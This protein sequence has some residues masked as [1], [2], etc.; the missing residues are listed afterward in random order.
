MPTYAQLDMMQSAFEMLTASENVDAA[1]EAFSMDLTAEQPACFD[2]TKNYVQCFSVPDDIDDTE[3]LVH[4]I[5]PK[6]TILGDLDESSPDDYA[7]GKAYFEAVREVI[8]TCEETSKY[9][10]ATYPWLD[11]DDFTTPNLSTSLVKDFV[12]VDGNTYVCAS[13]PIFQEDI[14]MPKQ[15]DIEMPKQEESVIIDLVGKQVRHS[16]DENGMSFV[17]LF[18]NDTTFVWNDLSSPDG[19]VTGVETYVRVEI[20]D[21]VV[22]YS[23]KES[24]LERD[25]G[26]A[27]TF[28]FSTKRVYGMIV[29]VF[30]DFNL[31]LSA[32]YTIID[33]LEVEDGLM[34][35]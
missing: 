8:S 19:I 27:W 32:D 14:A 2:P 33:N 5:A 1:V 18:C 12:A 20:S 15:E 7:M 3:I 6:G 23:W 9:N 11:S 31:N 21:E 35:C 13:G 4:P 26:L 30:P 24:P 10:L 34:T 16:W 22:Q 17:S 25:F 29:N 28:N